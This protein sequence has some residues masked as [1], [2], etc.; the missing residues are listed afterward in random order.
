MVDYSDMSTYKIVTQIFMHLA[1]IE[2][3]IG[4]VANSL[5]FVV[6]SRKRF[7]STSFSFYLR[8]NVLMDTV[9]LVKSILQWTGVVFEFYIEDVSIVFC[10]LQG[11]SYR[12]AFTSSTW[13]LS[14]IAFDRLIT[15]KYPY[16]F[17]YLK[18]RRLQI[19]LTSI[20]VAISMGFYVLMPLSLEYE[21]VVTVDE[22][23]NETSIEV[24]CTMEK[25]KYNAVFWI[26]LI[27]S[28]ITVV[29]LNNVLSAMAIVF[30][31][32]SRQRIRQ[33]N[34]SSN[35]RTAMRD[36][37]FAINSITLNLMSFVCKFPL[38]SYS[39]FSLLINDEDLDEMIS[40][41]CLSLSLVDN[42]SSLFVNML[43]N[44]IFYE[45]FLSI[46]RDTKIWRTN[47]SLSQPIE[48]VPISSLN[49]QTLTPEEKY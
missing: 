29:V 24:N 17:S 12:V 36:R 5:T 18:K 14:L 33:T 2:C 27:N 19:I 7:K 46:L 3:L 31:Y 45:E 35:E 34:S 42:S 10:K 16:R 11:Y 32:K 9:I 6:F 1:F 22:D 49:R 8:L 13:L 28:L 41:I 23:S 43:V 15:I 39:C 21:R 47:R 26:D 30:I 37:K 48:L 25:E 38:L 40:I 4:I 20:I 44:S